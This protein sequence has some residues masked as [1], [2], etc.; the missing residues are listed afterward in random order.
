M[1]LTECCALLSLAVPVACHPGR[2]RDPRPSVILVSVDTLRADHVGLYGYSRDTTPFLDRWARQGAVFEHAFSPVSWTLP[3]HMSMLTGLY[4][5]QHGVLEEEVALA[6]EVPLLAERLQEAG[7]QTVGLYFPGWVHERHGFAR[8]FD[9]FRSHLDAEEAADHVEE[10]LARLQ[11]EEPLFLFL[12]LFDVHS[13]PFTPGARAVY[14]SP[15]PF[16]E[17]FMAGAIERL[18]DVSMQELWESDRKL[19]PDERDALIALY[20]GGI[21]YVD[22]KLEAIFAGLARSGWLDGAL[23]I[24]TAD[25]GEALGLRGRLQG[26]G[27]FWQDGLHVPLVLRDPRGA[28]AGLRIREPVSLVD[29]VPTVLEAVG[30]RGD[31]GLGGRS[32]L[33]PLPP[34]RVLTGSRPPREYVVRWPEKIMRGMHG[35]YIGVDLERDPGEQHPVFVASERFVELRQVGLPGQATLHFPVAIPSLAP[36]EQEALRALGYGGESDDE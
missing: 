6:P 4:P 25:H 31:P 17:L 22:T 11:P 10:E 19:L 27:G 1:K 18:P 24:V 9:V 8:G 20:D 2:P 30:L 15:A 3:A 7:F 34:D 35:R 16:Q 14:E 29:L 21:R 32:L 26:H 36:A 33:G 23:V 12:H 28:L 13:A 5:V